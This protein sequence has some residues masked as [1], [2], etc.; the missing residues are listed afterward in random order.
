MSGVLKYFLK[1]YLVQY[2]Y[3]VF[4]AVV[5]VNLGY[6][7]ALDICCFLRFFRLN[8]IQLGF[9]FKDLVSEM[10]HLHLNVHVFLV[11]VVF[12]LMNLIFDRID[13]NQLSFESIMVL[14]LDLIV[15]Q[16]GVASVA[17]T[18]YLRILLR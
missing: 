12:K 16:Y 8:V 3:H 10:L 15:I 4:K 6:F 1:L 18:V 17:D 7:K 13:L 9:S 5:K 11:F 2:I 14:I